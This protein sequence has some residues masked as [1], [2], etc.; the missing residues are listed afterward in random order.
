M[1]SRAW[2]FTC[3]LL[4]ATP[5]LAQFTDPEDG[6]LD[7]SEWLIEK[8]GFLPVPILITEPAVGY[9][10]GLGLMFV[11]NS[12]RE[13]TE[14]QPAHVAP[15]DVFG[16]A[17]AATEN[18]TKFG[19]AG[20]MFS[21]DE[22]R[23]RYRGG[24]GKAEVNL[25]FYG[26]GGRLDTGERKIGYALDGLVSSQQVL[27]RLGETDSFVAARWI[28]LD[29]QATFDPAQPRPAL[30]PLSLAARSSGLGLALEYDSRDNIFTPSRG[31]LATFEP[32]FYSPSIGSD[33]KFELYKARALAWWPASEKLVLGGR[34]DGRAARG[35][36]PF[37]QLPYIEMR[38]IP[39]FRYQDDNVG[40]A[41][42]EL[43]WNATP[44]WA[45]IGFVGAGRTWG[46]G[47]TNFGDAGTVVAKGLG[48]RYLIA[49]RLGIYMGADIARGPEQTAFYIQVGSAWR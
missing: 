43:R 3:V 6:A 19:A 24:V 12:I 44:R 29:L 41:E 30:P 31:W 23:W 33:N 4:A 18:G 10:A 1:G 40:V 46:T 11:R 42:T 9:G 5:A 36:T 47:G 15:P 35:D 37:Y 38:G 21:F 26:A 14:E 45:I 7:A 39:A 28:Y 2:W 17:F 8:K 32:T 13:R 25:D 48:L 22:D 34:L 20:G 49:R 27:R 16:F